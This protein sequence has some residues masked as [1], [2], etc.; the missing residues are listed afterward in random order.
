MNEHSGRIL[1]V[2]DEP[3]V[4]NVLARHI[5]SAGFRVEIACSAE[6]AISLASEEPFDLLLIR[7]DTE[8]LGA[9]AVIQKPVELEALSKII[10]GLKLNCGVNGACS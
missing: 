3:Q 9:A 2:D 10:S 1:A 8:L 5:R 6:E 4:S 7:K